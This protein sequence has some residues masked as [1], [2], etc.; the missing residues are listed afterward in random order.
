MHATPAME[1]NFPRAHAEPMRFVAH[2]SLLLRKLMRRSDAL[3]FALVVLAVCALPACG[4]TS[5][6]AD[7]GGG[8]G[9]GAGGSGG[10][11]SCRTDTDCQGFKCCNG[12]CANTGNDILNC[13]TC[14]NTCGGSHPYCAGGT[15]QDGWPCSNVGATCD[16]GLTCCGSQCCNGTQICCS[17][18]MGPSFTGCFEPV[19]GTCPTGCAACV[20][21]APATP[22][23]T[24]AGARAIAALQVGDLV[25]SVDRGSLAVVPSERVHRE[26]V[27]GAHRM[28]ELKL[29]YGAPLRISPNHPTADGRRFG[30]LVAGDLLDGVR[31]LDARLVDYDEGF[32]YDILPA[33]DS[34]TYFA[35]GALIGSTLVDRPRDIT[36]SGPAA[37]AL[38]RASIR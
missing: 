26:P 2:L 38:R 28:M 30:D 17:V 22:I 21:A 36:T 27:T 20:C 7:A 24:P 10:R 1:K 11:Q 33:S 4:S 19:N 9:G 37:A 14:G 32:T 34:G 6:G 8:R 5:G 12:F 31:V 35:G 16:V 29:A 18:T 25:Y 23:A 13:G 15:C 3:R